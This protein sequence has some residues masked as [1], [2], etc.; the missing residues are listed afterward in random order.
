MDYVDRVN[1]AIDFVLGNLQRQFNLSDMADAACFSPFHFHRIFRGIVGETPSQFVKRLR[2]ERA[3]TKMAHD[4]RRSLTEIALDCG[5]SSSSDFS[6]SFKRRYSTPPS[7]FD[8]GAYR[9]S[10]RGELQMLVEQSAQN[11]RVERLPEGENPDGFSVRIRSL[12]A[13]TMAYFRVLD[14]YREH[15]VVDAATRLEEWA[16]LHGVA[17]NP[18]YGYMWDDPEVVEL[19]DCRYDVAVEADGFEPDGGIGRFEFPPMRVAQIEIRGAI[20][21]EMRALDWVYRTWLPTSRYVPDDLPCFEAWIGR[22]FAHGVEHFELYLQLPI[23]K[24]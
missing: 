15:V 16:R 7:A 6:R 20:D 2:L 9:A 5:F 22:P 17:D 24:V 23:R 10:K 1:R 21:L 19:K 3:L 14:P 8:M 11:L 12:P 18:W 13:R 4:P